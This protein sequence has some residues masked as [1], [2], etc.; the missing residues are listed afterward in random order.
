MVEV[1][2][3]KNEKLNTEATISNRV[4]P[5]FTCTQETYR[6][7]NFSFNQEAVLLAENN[8]STIYPLKIYSEK[9]DAYQR[10]Y[11]ISS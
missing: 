3:V 11:V 8:D 5:S 4:Y 1:S 6:Q 2:T 10:T 7:I 9:F